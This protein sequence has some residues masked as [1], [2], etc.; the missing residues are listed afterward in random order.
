MSEARDYRRH[1][2]TGQRFGRL[3]AV[4]RG[5]NDKNNHTTWVCKC[6]CGNTKIINANNLRTGK[7]QSCGCATK[8]SARKRKTTHGESKTRLYKIWAEIKERCY[9]PKNTSYKYYGERGIKMCNEWF[10]SYGTFKEWASTNGYT[11]ELTIDRINVNGN[12]EPNNCRWATYKEQA[13][14]KRNNRFIMFNNEIHTLAE[15]A[16]IVN[17][18][19][20]ILFMRL[21]RGWSE[22][23][24]LTTPIRDYSC[25]DHLGNVYSSMSEMCRHYG[26]KLATYS[27][28]IKDGYSQEDAL[29]IPVKKYYLEVEE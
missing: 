4:K 3:V 1:D 10:Y 29:T 9:S 6:D 8:E 25:K 14:N 20:D 2:L 24:T 22:E 15:W 11:D 26:I 17:I 7:S 27:R 21:K 23:K 16:D 13:N 19:Q 12:Y 28:R 18:D 5:E